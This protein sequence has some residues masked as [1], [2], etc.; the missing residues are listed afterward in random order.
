MAGI[1]VTGASGF[2]GAAIVR[3]LLR[4]SHRV[5]VLVRGDQ[6]GQRLQELSQDLTLI[7]GDP[8]EVTTFRNSLETFGADCVMHLGWAGVGGR[9]RNDVQTQL[10]NISMSVQL[11]ELTTSLQIPH[12]IGAGSQAEYGPQPGRI[13]ETTPTQ[14][15]TMYGAA[16]L[17]ACFMTERVC[18][19]AGIRHSWIRIFSTYG[20]GDNPDWM[21]PSL[22]RDLR[23]GKRPALTAGEQIWDYLQVDDA[24][25]AFTSVANRGA[26][27]IFNLGSGQATSLRKI[28]E[29]IRDA[30]DPALP[31]GFGEIPY[32]PDQVM[33][34]EANI[35]RLRE[36]AG[37]QPQ[38]SLER[39]LDELVKAE[40]GKL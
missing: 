13:A 32:R 38:I 3:Q 27:G 25:R 5:A 31:L 18:H 9:H 24:A 7:T 8:A 17:S 1:F 10:Q 28:I 29:T 14:P 4:S 37:W 23:A 22:I 30:V 11:A 20:P 33:H 6:P 39:G 36:L 16:K 40:Q 2:I 12:F 19:L 35:D 21:L 34:L 26:E 15:T